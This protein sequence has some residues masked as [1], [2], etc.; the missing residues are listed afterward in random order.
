MHKLANALISSCVISLPL[1]ENCPTHLQREKL[2]QRRH[3][4]IIGPVC[5]PEVWARELRAPRHSEKC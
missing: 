4:M 2:K 1:D 3:G 5:S